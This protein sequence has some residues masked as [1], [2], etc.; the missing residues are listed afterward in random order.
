MIISK[1]GRFKKYFYLE[2]GDA[3]PPIGCAAWNRW[4]SRT[5][6]APSAPLSAAIGGAE[7]AASSLWLLAHCKPCPSCSCPIQKNDGCNHM[8]CTKVNFD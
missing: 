8:K 6:A 7:S 3:H 2:S 4:L 1:I 5:G